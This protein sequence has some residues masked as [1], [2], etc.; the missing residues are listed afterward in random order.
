MKQNLIQFPQ[1]LQKQSIYYKEYLGHEYAYVMFG[2]RELMFL[3]TNKE[4]N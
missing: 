1:N 3:I 2:D 4:I